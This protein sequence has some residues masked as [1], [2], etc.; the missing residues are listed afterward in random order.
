MLGYLLGDTPYYTI[1][2]LIL[3]FIVEHRYVKL[4]VAYS[5]IMA[6]DQSTTALL[7]ND[8]FFGVKA[9]WDLLWLLATF[10]FVNGRLCK[11]LST[12]IAASLF[13]NVYLQFNTNI[14]ILYT[15]WNEI[16]FVLFEFIIAALISTSSWYKRLNVRLVKISNRIINKINIKRISLCEEK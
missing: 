14:N 6:V 2:F 5:L 10:I 16:N 9:V 3:P 4:C 1:L 13:I 11:V 12:C 15:Y 7:N 8:N